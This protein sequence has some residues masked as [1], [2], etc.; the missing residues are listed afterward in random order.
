M[1]YLVPLF[2]AMHWV[3]APGSNAKV[4]FRKPSRLRCKLSRDCD[5]ERQRMFAR[6]TS[7]ALSVPA[8]PLRQTR[9]ACCSI[10]VMSPSH[11]RNFAIMAA[12]QCGRQWSS[13]RISTKSVVPIKPSIVRA[14]S[15]RA[16]PFMAGEERWI[17]MHLQGTG[18]GA[19]LTLGEAHW[20]ASCLGA[21][22][23]A[24]FRRRRRDRLAD[25]VRNPAADV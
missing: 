18:T 11:H 24:A 9:F 25:P 8:L 7:V 17:I 19:M 2:Q 22:R 16:L 15:T 3:H 6:Y 10:L 21:Y 4:N 20:A 12:G 14:R 5:G 1:L 13:R 23:D